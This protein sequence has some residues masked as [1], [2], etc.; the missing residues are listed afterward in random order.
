MDEIN[1]ILEKTNESMGK[2]IEFMNKELST[3]RAGKAN[4]NILNNISVDYYGNPTPINQIASITT[5]DPKTIMIKPW[6]KNIIPEIEK[7]IM[8]S[9][10]GLNAQ[11]DSE[12]IIINIPPLTEERRLVLVKQ[13]KNEGEKCKITIRNIRK[14][15]NDSLK[16]LHEEGLSEDSIRSGESEIQEITN[17]FINKIDN[18]IS[19]KEKEILKV[20]Y[21]QIISF[22]FN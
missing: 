16:K 2:S 5:P 17:S 19:S 10:T 15:S 20:Y 1:K 7:S 3:I 9:D 18:L 4:P 14:E 13:V 22:I 12:T 6:D 8:N 21:S 11:N